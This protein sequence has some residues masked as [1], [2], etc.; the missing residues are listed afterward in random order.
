MR[1]EVRTDTDLLVSC[2]ETWR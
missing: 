2:D 1:D